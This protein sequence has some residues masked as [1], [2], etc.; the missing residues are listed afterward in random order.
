MN[1]SSLRS[2]SGSTVRA[3]ANPP[4]SEL[5]TTDGLRPGRTDL[6]QGMRECVD[7]LE[8][9]EDA[10]YKMLTASRRNLAIQKR[11]LPISALELF[12]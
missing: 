3:H 1:N 12:Q 5:R 4:E 11:D 9:A 7:E 6:P 8:R 10:F 2:A